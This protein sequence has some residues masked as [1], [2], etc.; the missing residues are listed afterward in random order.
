MTVNLG[1][2]V[3]WFFLV[4]LVLGYLFTGNDSNLYNAMFLTVLHYVFVPM[5]YK[6]AGV[7]TPGREQ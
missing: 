4:F 2:V 6:K 1:S 3:Y 5:I 7:D